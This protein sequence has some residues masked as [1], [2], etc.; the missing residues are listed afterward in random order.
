MNYPSGNKIVRN[1]ARQSAR[2]SLFGGKIAI[3]LLD[4]RQK[5]ASHLDSR[6]GISRIRFIHSITYIMYNY[7]IMGFG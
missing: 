7:H 2:R 3:L 1:V 5:L 6:T 4:V